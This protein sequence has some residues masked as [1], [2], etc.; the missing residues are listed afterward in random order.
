MRRTIFVA[1]TTIGIALSS[2]SG[3]AAGP[4]Q[5]LRVGNWSGGSYTNDK[6]GA[7]S[8][9]VANAPYNSGISFF[10]SVNSSFQW[11]I[12]FASP[13]WQLV[14]GET[15][16]VDLTF[17][18]R[19]QYHVFATALTSQLA[20][21][22]MPSNSALI[23]TFREARQMQAVAKGQL[24]GF[25]LNQTSMLLPALVDC[26]RR[27]VGLPVI[28]KPAA[29][30]TKVAPL[31]STLAPA[32]VQP[33]AVSPSANTELQIE[34]INLATNFMLK[35]HAPNPQLFNGQSTPTELAS[36]GAAW[37]SDDA[38]GAVKII[39]A[40][41]GLKGIELAADVARSDATECK[42]KF[43]SGR[44]SDLVDSDVVFRGFSTCEDSEGI[45]SSLYFLVPRKK[46]GFVL[47]SV[48]SSGKPG[49]SATATSDEKLPDY[50][51]AA[52]T[53]VSD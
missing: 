36:W 43:L 38:V 33:S 44:A 22:P 3:H 48:V 18:G 28:A 31:V 30:V 53:S 52:L 45:R 21:I 26:V 13:A 1:A 32:P 27:N 9:C 23:R 4:V 12:G 25:N 11:S 17:D 8:H 46:G 51:K 34:A 2:V 14:S 50:R 5:A 49:T 20:A 7:F 40:Q 19:S 15:I 10:V 16:P 24:F 6:T 35:S 29:P 39:P 42:G 41:A 47:F 37:K